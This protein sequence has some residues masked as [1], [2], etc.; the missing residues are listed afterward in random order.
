MFTYMNFVPLCSLVLV[1]FRNFLASVFNVKHYIMLYTGLFRVWA[2]KNPIISTQRLNI[3]TAS[4]LLLQH[5][6]F[7]IT[8]WIICIFFFIS[9]LLPLDAFNP[10]QEKIMRFFCFIN[11]A[12]LDWMMRDWKTFP[13]YL[14]PSSSHSC[15][16]FKCILCRKWLLY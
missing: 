16:Y 3:I 12:C 14:S 15:C 9:L 1:F 10:T 4:V 7:H 5:H 13:E 11:W 8:Y 6:F 2:H